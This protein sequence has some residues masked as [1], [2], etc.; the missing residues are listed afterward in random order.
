MIKMTMNRQSWIEK[1]KLSQNFGN[2]IECGWS[3]SRH[4]Y[5]EYNGSLEK[6]IDTAFYDTYLETR[7]SKQDVA[8]ICS[9]YGYFSG[10]CVAV[11]AVCDEQYSIDFMDRGIRR[12]SH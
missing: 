7:V 3:A 12:L 9:R 4:G 6:A 5:Q 2:C 11:Y 1:V 10:D 8:K